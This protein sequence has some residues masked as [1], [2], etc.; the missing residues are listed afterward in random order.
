MIILLV[1]LLGTSINVAND[2]PTNLAGVEDS[3]IKQITHPVITA[4]YSH[5][6]K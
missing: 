4:D 6:N 5:L 2:H 1:L 3:I